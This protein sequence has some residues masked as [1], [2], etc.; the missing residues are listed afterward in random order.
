MFNRA[1]GIN[2][3]NDL[4]IN[5]FEI[6]KTIALAATFFCIIGSYSILRPLKTSVFF[7]LVG[8]EYQPITKYVTI[9][10]LIP[11]LLLYAKLVDKLKRYQLVYI[12]LTFYSL[13][14]LLFA[15][16]LTNPYIG[17]QNTNA[18]PNRILGWVFYLFID[19]FAPLVVSTFWAFVNSVSTPQNASKSYGIIVA[20]SRVAGI[21]TP[22]LSW[23]LLNTTNFN[24]IQIIPSLV[25]VTSIL[26][27]SGAFIIKGITKKVPM[28]YLESYEKKHTH[29]KK[30]KKK[31]GMLDGL[32][33]M[34]KQPYVFGIFALTY[35]FELISV[36]IDYQMQVLMSIANNNSIGGMSS[37]M[38]LYTSAFQALALVFA[39][40]G[41][42]TLLKRIGTQKCLLIMPISVMALMGSLLFSPNLTTIF[43][44]MV[45]LRSLHYGFNAPVK[46]TL[47]I[48]T[49]KDIKFKSKTWID[50][51]GKRL[52]KASGSTFNLWAQ[53]PNYTST[54]KLD[55][56]FSIGIAAGW[57]VIS[58]MVGK[59][60]TETIENGEIIGEEIGI[61]PA[62]KTT[63][64]P[65]QL[66]KEKEIGSNQG[67]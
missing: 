38:F 34:L 59:K 31:S 1:V 49:T 4:Q 46:E 16:L 51:F 44:I 35:S 48:P 67:L 63:I 62:K 33:S 5:K 65:K 50:A 36:I 8:R 66:P 26:L 29:I 43:I 64:A 21:I 25:I 53:S 12:F 19:L 54:L 55:S 7:S 52:S 61:S 60:Y 58:V 56:L 14:S 27:I 10:S 47:Y 3:N 11:I 9:L 37:Y 28:Q 57:T 32:I 45:V 23:L 30:V 13:L 2:N 6:I 17:L 40:F 39:V 41:T 18:S 22:A 42:S 20:V 24:P 15:Y